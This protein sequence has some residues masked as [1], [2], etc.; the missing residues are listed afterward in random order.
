LNGR[1]RGNIIF[2]DVLVVISALAGMLAAMGVAIRIEGPR[3][4]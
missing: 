1:P 3:G 4:Q 2:V